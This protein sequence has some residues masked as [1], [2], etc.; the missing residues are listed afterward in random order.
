MVK[1][2]ITTV[3]CKGSFFNRKTNERWSSNLCSIKV[4]YNP[5]K[6][7]IYIIRVYRQKSNTSGEWIHPHFKEDQ[8]EIMKKRAKWN[9]DTFFNKKG[10]ELKEKSGKK[11]KHHKE[12]KCER[13]MEKGRYCK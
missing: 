2:Y 11:N 13:C 12:D 6:D 9:Y 10:I 3:K 5:K 7:K 1:G 4:N 8:F